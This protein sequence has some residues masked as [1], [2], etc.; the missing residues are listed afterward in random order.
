MAYASKAEQIKGQLGCVLQSFF[1]TYNSPDTFHKVFQ[2]VNGTGQEMTYKLTLDFMAD[3]KIKSLISS[4][5][6]TV[7]TLMSGKT[8]EDTGE[9]IPGATVNGSVLLDENLNEMSPTAA[10]KEIWKR[11][12]RAADRHEN[13]VIFHVQMLGTGMDLPCLN[14]VVILG[15]KNETDLFQTIMRGCRKDPADPSKVSYHVFIYVPAEVQSYMKSFIDCLDKKGGPELIA[16]FSNDVKQGSGTGEY[17]S[18]FES[19]LT[20]TAGFN[21][22]EEAYSQVI[23]CESYTTKCALIKEIRNKMLEYQRAGKTAEYEL[24]REKWFQLQEELSR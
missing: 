10:R 14:S 20:G 12:Y 22:V 17:E 23:K 9:V 1:T 15:D 4:G 16:A 19:L 21:Q 24:M 18:I 5:N 6:L 7:F 2:L 3:P 8:L 13:F 11:I